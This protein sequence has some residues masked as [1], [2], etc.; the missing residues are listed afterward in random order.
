IVGA[1]GL[2]SPVAWLLAQSGVRRFTLADDDVVALDNLH[3]QI[4]YR[5]EDVGLPKVEVL[6]RR[7]RTA[8]ATDVET[9]GR[10]VPETAAAAVSDHDL[11][12]EGADNFATKFLVADACGIARVPCAQAGVVR[13]S[14]WALLADGAGAHACLRC[15]FEDV[16]RHADTCSE[17]GVVGPLVGVIA[18]LQ[19]RLALRA[20]LGDDVAGTLHAFD[21]G[22]D[23]EPRTTRVRA[24]RDCPLCGTHDIASIREDRYL[25]GCTADVADV[26]L[27]A[28]APTHEP[29]GLPA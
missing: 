4:L 3:R 5:D 27:A 21:L 22:R 23:R 28:S 6:A 14:G 13:R 10:V 9:M 29:R 12:V 2:G 11:V 15:L 16:P 1:G 25:S 24:R 18:A 19:A 20:L 7:L 26:G 8:G 17:A